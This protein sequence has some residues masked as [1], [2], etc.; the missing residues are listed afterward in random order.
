VPRHE[1][2][3][4]YP[5]AVERAKAEYAAMADDGGLPAII[6]SRPARDQDRP[7]SPLAVPWSF[8]LANTETATALDTRSS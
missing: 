2:T 6:R 4:A 8:F 1:K 7:T 5:D 3:L